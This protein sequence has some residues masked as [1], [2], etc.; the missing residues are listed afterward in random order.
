[1]NGYNA[2]AAEF[3]IKRL[4]ECCEG[5]R[6]E[7]ERKDI[8]LA[9][10][11]DRATELNARLEN[12]VSKDLFEVTHEELDRFRDALTKIAD[13]YP[14]ESGDAFGIAQEALDPDG[15]AK[16]ARLKPE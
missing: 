1:M 12:S 9:M 16:L 5:Y 13:L 11:R 10:L 3:E 8:L 15:C 6:A 2:E 7:L 14:G 4:Q